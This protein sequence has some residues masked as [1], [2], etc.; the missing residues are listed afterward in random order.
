M[1]N[2]PSQQS[3]VGKRALVSGDKK[4]HAAAYVNYE[5][6]PETWQTE[7]LKELV[8]RVSAEILHNFPVTCSGRTQWTGP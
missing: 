2:N 5:D 6:L 7:V 4:K 3:K 8:K 1:D